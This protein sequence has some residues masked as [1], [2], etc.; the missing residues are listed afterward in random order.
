M[1]KFGTGVDN[2]GVGGV[3][4]GK[5]CIGVEGILEEVDG[6]DTLSSGEA[7]SCCGKED[8]GDDILNIGEA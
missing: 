8:A 7:G 4:V 6:V 1:L 5:D 3:C 2:S